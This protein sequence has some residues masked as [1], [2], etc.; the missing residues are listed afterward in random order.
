MVNG[1]SGGAG[2]TVAVLD[3]GVFKDHL[4]LDVQLC[5]DATKRGIKNGCNDNNGHGTHVSGTVAGN[6]GT[7]GLG[8]TGVA[9][10]AN[11]CMSKG[12]VNAGCW[13]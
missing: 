3:T 1:G 9:P 12:C 13:S 10:N 6:G 7:D 5:K 8:I 2:V 11:F 4:D